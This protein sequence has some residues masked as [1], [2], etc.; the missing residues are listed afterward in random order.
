MSPPGRKWS[1]NTSE[2]WSHLDDGSKPV[3]TGDAGCRQ[4]ARAIWRPYTV[5]HWD[6]TDQGWCW[7]SEGREADWGVITY[8]YGRWYS[9]PAYGWVWIPGSVWAP[10]WVA[11]R[12]GDGYCGWYPL[13]PQC[14][15]G[16]DLQPV[17]VERYCPADRFVYCDE[18]YITERQVYLHV[19]HDNT[20]IINRTT[21]ITNITYVNNRIVNRG[22]AVRDV[23]ERSGRHIER[24]QLTQSTDVADARRLH[25]EG[26]PVIYAPS[27]VRKSEPANAQRLE[28]EMVRRSASSERIAAQDQHARSQQDSVRT[29]R[30]GEKQLNEQGRPQVQDQAAER[31]QAAQRKETIS[32]QGEAEREEAAQASRRERVGENPTAKQSDEERTAAARERTTRDRNLTPGNQDAAAADRARAAADREQSARAAEQERIARERERRPQDRNADEQQIARDSER[33][34]SAER[35]K[36]AQAEQERAARE[37]RRQSTHDAAAERTAAERERA[38]QAQQERSARRSSSAPHT[39]PQFSDRRKMPLQTRRRPSGQEPLAT[40]R[41]RRRVTNRSIRTTIGIRRRS[42]SF[43]R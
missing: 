5:G 42:S 13:P 9:E 14:G 20:R 27:A 12:G 2:T 7:S 28:R 43:W 40:S 37:Q 10:A 18:R 21:N 29:A 30:E 22:V 15:E 34:Q 1:W 35:E 26:R 8:H 33:K 25:Q 19:E 41:S 24:A 17:V 3:I 11:W 23:E 36:A 6:D 39:M 4:I 31:Q 16:V 32:R 38:A